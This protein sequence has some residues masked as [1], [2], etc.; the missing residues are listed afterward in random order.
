MFIILTVRSRASA[1]GVGA[2]QS[3]EMEMMMRTLAAILVVFCIA[4][5]FLTSCRGSTT[6]D[7]PQNYFSSSDINN[8][9][10]Q[11]GGGTQ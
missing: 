3:F 9:H 8:G 1:L 5:F 10:N 6:L 2:W 4:L 11:G 7:R